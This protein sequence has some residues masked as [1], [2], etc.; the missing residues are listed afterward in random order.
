MSHHCQ[1]ISEDLLILLGDFPTEFAHDEVLIQDRRIHT[2]SSFPIRLCPGLLSLSVELAYLQGIF[3]IHQRY[4]LIDKLF[5]VY[6]IIYIYAIYI[7]HELNVIYVYSVYIYLTG[8]LHITGVNYWLTQYK[9]NMYS[10]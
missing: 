5:K 9:C 2:E 10:L 7:Y 6:N 4:A 3:F 1:K 8:I